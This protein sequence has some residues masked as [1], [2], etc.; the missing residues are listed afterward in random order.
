[1]GFN[2]RLREYRL[3]IKVK[4]KRL[5]AKKL[6]ISEQLYYM[7][8]SGTRE[9]SKDVLRRLFLI[10]KQPEEYWKY[11]ITDEMERIEKRDD[12]KCLKDAIDQLSNIGL[13]KND[14]K[15]F[16]TS[17]EEVLNAA[18]KADVAHR[19]DKIE[20]MKASKEKE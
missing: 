1:M 9:P 20:L 6:G 2:E 15:D 17:V 19:L 18:M 13:L 4:T 8:E 11:G 5:M 10:S 14:G 16:S 7:L 3:E 12:F